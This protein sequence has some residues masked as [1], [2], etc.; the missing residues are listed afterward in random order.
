[1]SLL[2]TDTGSRILPS[3]PDI[4]II[5]VLFY[6]VFFGDHNLKNTYDFFVAN[7]HHNR[8]AKQLVLISYQSCSSVK[9]SS[10]N[11]M[12]NFFDPSMILKF[13]S[14]VKLYFCIRAINLSLSKAFP[15]TR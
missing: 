1:M 14:T 3:D 10:N 5:E 12:P 15:N 13:S 9:G 7:D 11:L 8:D 6:T 4:P 2:V